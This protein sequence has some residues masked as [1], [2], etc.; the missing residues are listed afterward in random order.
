[1]RFMMLVRATEDTE[2]GRWPGRAL[3]GELVAFN[4]EMIRAGVL[5]ATDGLQPSAKGARVWVSNGRRVVVDG[6]FGE[7]RE[8]VAGY[9]LIQVK[10]KDEAIEWASRIPFADR[11]AIEVRQVVD[12][13]DLPAD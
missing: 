12:A 3:A 11:N 8:L 2:A 13:S 1:M 9:W 4:E 10:S 6:P 5:L 7:F